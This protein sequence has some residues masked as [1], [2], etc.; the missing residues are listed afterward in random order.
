MTVDYIQ[1]SG[2]I[3]RQPLWKTVQLKYFCWTSILCWSLSFNVC[4]WFLKCFFYHFFRSASVKRIGPE[5]LNLEPWALPFWN[6]WSLFDVENANH[7][8]RR[9]LISWLGQCLATSANSSESRLQ[10]AA[11]IW[12]LRTFKKFFKRAS[13]NLVILYF[14]PSKQ[15][16]AND[17]F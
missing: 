11:N 6:K 10:A 7:S 14:R 4:C 2:R 8:S 15:E 16:V 3:G 9:S 1:V 13:H 12:R 17:P 5:L